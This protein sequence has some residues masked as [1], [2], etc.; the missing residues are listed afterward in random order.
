MDFRPISLAF[1]NEGRLV[2]HDMRSLRIWSPGALSAQTPPNLQ[3]PL[4]LVKALFNMT[5]LSRTS[6]GRTMVLLRSSGVFLW[7]AASPEKIVTVVPPPGSDSDPAAVPSINGTNRVTTFRAIQIAPRGDRLYLIDQT[8]QLHVWALDGPSEAGTSATQAR[9]LDWSIPT[10]A[11]GGFTNLAL[12]GDGA[13]LALGDRMQKVTLVNTSNQTI[14][15]P[16]KPTDGEAESWG[17]AMAFSPNGR[18]LAVG[19]DKGTISLWSIADPRRPRLQ[20][21]LPGHRAGIT[22]SLVFD[23]KGRR[24]ASAGMDPLVEVW[25]LELIQHEL[26]SLQLAD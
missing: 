18:E 19:S 22:T 24:L 8:G 3:V 12:R 5:P 4:P 21:R 17:L 1:D 7:H 26:V 15:Q 23:A 20:F 9:A 10:T 2:T 13:M 25:D 6:D 11:E 14:F 16:L